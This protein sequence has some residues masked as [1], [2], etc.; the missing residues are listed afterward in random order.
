M[1]FGI[2][3]NISTQ[4]KNVLSVTAASFQTKTVQLV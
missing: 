2:R 1:A 4:K 3:T